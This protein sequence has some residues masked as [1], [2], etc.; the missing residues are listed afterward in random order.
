MDSSSFIS[1]FDIRITLAE[2]PGTIESIGIPG[3]YAANK[4]RPSY[5]FAAAYFYSIRSGLR[6]RAQLAELT[7]L[8]SFSIYLS[9]FTC[10][11]SAMSARESEAEIE[12]WASV[13]EQK[14]TREREREGGDEEKKGNRSREKER[15]RIRVGD[16]IANVITRRAFSPQLTERTGPEA[17]GPRND[18]T[19][20]EGRKR[21]R[22]KLPPPPPLTAVRLYVDEPINRMILQIARKRCWTRA[23]TLFVCRP[24][25]YLLRVQ[26]LPP[27]LRG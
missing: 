26:P 8:F 24:L 13:R 15:E 12:G 27:L 14:W 20:H 21:V 25:L 18:D 4:S 1:F 17:S 23:N 22:R 5:K 2:D 3:K 7:P 10:N 16:R 11:I 6:F 19:F 9:L